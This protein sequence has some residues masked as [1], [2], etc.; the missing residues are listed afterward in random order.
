MGDEGRTKGTLVQALKYSSVASLFMAAFLLM[1]PEPLFTRIFNKPGLMEIIKFLSISLPFSS[2]MV[3]ALNATQG[4][5]TMHYTIY[6]QNLFSPTSNLLLSILF[7]LIGFKVFGVVIAYAVS[8]FLTSILSIYF[9]TRIFPD[10]KSARAVSETKELFRF[11]I[12]FLFITFLMFLILYTDILFLGHFRSSYEVGIYNAAVKTALFINAI[13]LC[14]SHIFSPIISDLHGRGETQK[15]E[16]LFKTVTGWT[17]SLS[18]PIF[19]FILLSSKE[20]MSVFGQGF[21]MGWLPLI[22][23]AFAQLLNAATGPATHILVMSARQDFMLLNCSI[24]CLINILLN[25]LLIPSH[26]IVGAS[27]ASGTSIVIFNLTMLFKIQASLKM[28]PYSKKFLKPT[29][30][31]IVTYVILLTANLFSFTIDPLPKL[32]L[33]AIIFFPLYAGLMYT[34]GIDHEDK[35]VMDVIKKKILILGKSYR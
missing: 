33:S 35:M 24:V 9:L 14:F 1:T 15:L 10:V 34:S 26:G 29:A 25:Y 23:L 11:S 28:H 6:G 4:F 2:L 19:L 16:R 31:G 21:I 32:L 30:F 20:I 17:Y 7:F 13:L 5:K 8:A 27:L 18:L 3:V 12:P 22:I